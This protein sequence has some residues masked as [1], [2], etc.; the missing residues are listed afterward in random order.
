MSKVSSPPRC[1]PPM[2]PVTKTFKPAL[3]AS[4]MVA[5]TVVAPLRPRDM[6]SPPS[7]GHEFQLLLADADAWDAFYDGDSCRRSPCL[8][9]DCLHLH[10]SL[11]ILRIGHPCVGQR[12]SE[13]AERLP[14]QMAY[15]G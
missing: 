8:S 5:D 11:Q 9:Y 13:G 6:T 12:L 15:R 4:T 10:G 7:P 1:T 2:P 3:A 14:G